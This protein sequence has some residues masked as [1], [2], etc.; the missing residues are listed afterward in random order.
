M[1]NFMLFF[2]V[3]AV[4]FQQQERFLDLLAMVPIKAVQNV[5]NFSQAQLVPKL[6]F[7]ALNHAHQEATIS[8]GNLEPNNRR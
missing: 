6:I 5:R 3:L 8:T 2:F 7:R 4:K 1:P